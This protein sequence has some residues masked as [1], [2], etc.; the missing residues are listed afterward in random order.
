MYLSPG[1]EI[2]ESVEFGDGEVRRSDADRGQRPVATRRQLR[3]A[4]PQIVEAD[5]DGLP[6]RPA[7]EG[8]CC[9]GRLR[10][11]ADDVKQRYRPGGG[12][13]GAEGFELILSGAVDSVD[14][15]DPAAAPLADEVAEHGVE[16]FTFDHLAR[17]PGHVDEDLSAPALVGVQ[18]RHRGS[19][20]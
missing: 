7:A 11:D 13:R 2:G 9:G 19:A 8:P 5:T 6:W 4:A 10:C 18:A 12:G 17:Q 3:P 1:E 20:G 16:R 14:D 15:R